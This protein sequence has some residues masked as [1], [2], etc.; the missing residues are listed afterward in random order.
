[1]AFTPF[2]QIQYLADTKSDIISATANI[3]IHNI[4]IFNASADQQIAQLYL[5]NGSTEYPDGYYTLT[6]KNKA[7]EDWIGAGKI[8][9]NGWVL[10]G[11]ASVASTCVI[12]ITGLQES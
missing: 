5:Y 2:S 10:R 1:M 8:L 4:M 12:H 9:K 11:S 7:F 6:T 3:H